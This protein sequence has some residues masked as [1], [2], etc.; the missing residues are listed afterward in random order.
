V[1]PGLSAPPKHAVSS[2]ISRSKRESARGGPA[3]RARAGL[4]GEIG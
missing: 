4:L 1:S 2:E 3:L